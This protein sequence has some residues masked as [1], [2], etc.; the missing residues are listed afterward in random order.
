MA[1]PIKV[2]DKTLI[3][4][5]DHY[6]DYCAENDLLPIVI[7]FAN[8]M[9]L[10]SNRLYERAK[11]NPKLSTSIKR[12][13]DKKQVELERGGLI[14]KYSASMAI[15][16]LKQLGWKDKVDVVENDEDD[17]SGVIVI[18]QVNADE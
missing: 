16:S 4:G 8:Y 15:F 1:R 11:E 6:L 12:I 10:S 13:T 9:G 7:D 2:S 5:V 3:E 14:G 17:D 18:P